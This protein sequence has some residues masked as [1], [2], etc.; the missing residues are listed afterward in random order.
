M[1]YNHVGPDGNYLTQ[2]SDDYFTDR[3]KNEWG[4]AINFDGENSGPVR[5]WVTTNAAYW[6]EEYHLD[7]LR[8]DATQQIFDASPENIMTALAKSMRAA[9]RRRGRSSSWRRTNRSTRRLVRPAGT[10]RLRPR[11]SVERRFPSHRARGRDRPQRGLLHRLPGHAAGADLRGEV[12]LPLPGA[13]LHV[14]GEAARHS[15]LGTAPGAVRELSS[16]ITTRSPTP[17]AASA[18]TD[19]PA[20][21]ATAR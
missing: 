17:A 12:R 11:R 4:E 7:G 5:E 16:R 8:L 20:R 19:S 10:G 14:A 1:V 3:Y 13:A 15:G 2:F 9:A 18:C 6:A 21:A